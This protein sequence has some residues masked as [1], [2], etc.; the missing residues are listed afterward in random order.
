MELEDGGRLAL[1]CS[2]PLQAAL[3]A[4]H[5]ITR[6]VARIPTELQGSLA[7]RFDAEGHGFIQCREAED[8]SAWTADLLTTAAVVDGGE[9]YISTGDQVA[10]WADAR[11]SVAILPLEDMGRELVLMLSTFALP[12]VGSWRCWWSLPVL[13]SALDSD[14]SRGRSGF[15]HRC[16]QAWATW[17]D[18]LGLGGGHLRRAA[19]TWT[20]LPHQAASSPALDMDDKHGR[21]CHTR[22]HHRQRCSL[23]V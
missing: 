10:P 4:Q 15:I 23:D 20:T 3:V 6:E 16:F 12:Q 22:P 5:S 11:H 8:K 1:S 17:L 2:R 19:R 13:A 21:P 14:R 7:L 18:K 9:P